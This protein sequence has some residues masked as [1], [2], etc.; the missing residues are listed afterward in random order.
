M[1]GEVLHSAAFIVA[2][3]L[4]LNIPVDYVNN[5]MTESGEDYARITRNSNTIPTMLLKSGNLLTSTSMILMV[6]CDHAPGAGL[7]YP[8]GTFE[9][10]YL[11]ELLLWLDDLQLYVEHLAEPEVGGN[12]T[13]RSFFVKQLEE[14][15]VYFDHHILSR[16]K[17][18]IQQHLTVADIYFFTIFKSTYPLGLSRVFE[19]CPL[20]Q[21]YMKRL[22]LLP[23]IV[24][25][26]ALMAQLA[27]EKGIAAPTGA[28]GENLST[29][30]RSLSPK[31]SAPEAA[32]AAPVSR[33]A[34]VKRRQSST[35]VPPLTFD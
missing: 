23:K 2:F 25:A 9:R 34:S 12:P 6:L 13:L 27:K 35:Q 5:G 22:H 3:S 21:G 30:S 14:R 8:H 10:V 28:I 32:S 29:V 33:P 16:D 17:K 7:S 19:L 1:D 24:G 4:G 15:L 26:E 20:I 11:F 31:K 18:Y